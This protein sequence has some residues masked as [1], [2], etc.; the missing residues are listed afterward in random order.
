MIALIDEFLPPAECERLRD[1]LVQALA[2]GMST[3]ADTQLSEDFQGREIDYAHMTDE[4]VLDIADCARRQVAAIA[5]ALLG[6][7]R[8][9]HLLHRPGALARGTGDGLS[10]R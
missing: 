5:A 2:D 3:P 8:L 10:R 6:W 9:Y 1:Y 7:P 4:T